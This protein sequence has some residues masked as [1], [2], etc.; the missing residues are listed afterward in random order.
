MVN[1]QNQMAKTKPLLSP[2]RYPG[3]KRGLVGYIKETLEINS[4]KPSLYIEPFLGGGSV[5]INLLKENLIQCAILVDCDPWITS[6]WHTVFFDTKWLIE[7]IQTVEVSIEKWN[8]FKNANPTNIRDQALTC[9]FLNRTSFSGIL[10]KR[11]GPIGGKDQKSEYPI[12]CRFTS[13]TRNTII[14]RIEQISK[15]QNQIYGVWNC[16]WNEA[17]KKIRTEQIEGKLP[18][19]NLFF[20]LDP[21]FFE[22]ADALYRFY[23]LEQDHKDLRDCLLTLEDKWLLSYDSAEQVEALYGDALK[24][25]TNGTR[26]HDIELLY[27]IAKVSK[28]KKGK[29]VIIS[30]LEQLPIPQPIN[31]KIPEIPIPTESC[32][33]LQDFTLRE[34]I[35]AAQ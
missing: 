21:P 8:S 31:S 27:T 13:T 10:E 20:Y 22:E 34:Q 17:L 14:G 3:S 1:K 6:F 4:L 18:T 26:H 16:S 15:F 5:A 33:I 25:S 2:L 29:E 32:G 12:D 28:R 24:R 9:F 35:L 23:F 11:A 7:Q 19:S 30:N